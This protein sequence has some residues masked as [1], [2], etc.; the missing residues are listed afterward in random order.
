MR[1]LFGCDV[2][3]SDHT[4]GVGV[5]IA[6]VSLGVGVI[7]KHLTLNRD[8]GGVDS[9]F[10][11]VPSE[12]KSLV[13]ETERAWAGQGRPMYGPT[14]AELKSFVFRRSLYVTEDLQEGD[15]L[16]DSNVRA[17]RPGYGLPTKFL[18]SVLGKRVNRVVTRGTAV[19]WDLFG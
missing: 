8:D 3:L 18:N 14:T 13:E 1:E 7:E 11:L 6:G 10:S 15:L 9:A 5:A 12:L 19:S 4:L 16:T 2:G 17:L